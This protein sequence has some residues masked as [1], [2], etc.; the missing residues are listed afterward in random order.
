[1]RSKARIR[2]GK[3]RKRKEA[4]WQRMRS[5]KSLALRN[6]ITKEPIKLREITFY[7]DPTVKK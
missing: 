7:I 3:F 6:P 4:G 2:D 1:M 5:L